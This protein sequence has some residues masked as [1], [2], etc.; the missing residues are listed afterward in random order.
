MFDTRVDNTAETATRGLD[1]AVRHSFESG[2]NRFVFDVN[3]NHVLA[4]DN[5]LTSTS[6][7]TRSLDRI[8]GPLAWRVGGGLGWN[9]GPWDGSL[10]VNYAGDYRDDRGVTPVP[11]DGYA[12]VDLS[13][14]YTFDAGA[15]ASLRGLRL[16]FHVENLLDAAP[17]AVL[18]DA[19]RTTGLG[20]DPVNASGRG[21]FVSFQLRKSW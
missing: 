20:Y 16:S 19:G 3:V 4:F 12:T 7:I 11:V 10:H 13:L 15:P 17:P 9:R 6:P 8:Y 14:S 2:A 5:R 21:R 18:P 1:F